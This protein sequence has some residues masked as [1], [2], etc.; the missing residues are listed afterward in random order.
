MN[1]V[2]ARLILRYLAGALI[3]AG[4]LDPTLGNTI[5]ADPDLIVLFG[6]LVGALAEGLYIVARRRGWR[7]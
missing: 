3:A 6:A 5:S 2:I 4:Y 7:T 1:L